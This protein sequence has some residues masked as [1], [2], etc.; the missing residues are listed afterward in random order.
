[1]ES[2]KIFVVVCIV[3]IQYTNALNQNHLYLQSPIIK[4]TLLVPPNRTLSIPSDVPLAQVNI[5]H[6]HKY[7]VSALAC[8]Y[9]SLKILLKSPLCGNNSFANTSNRDKITGTIRLVLEVIS[10]QNKDEWTPSSAMA[11]AWIKGCSKEML[12]M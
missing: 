3:L 1:M 12:M 8:I 10:N 4:T 2:S 7:F 5:F 11:L 9:H 6:L